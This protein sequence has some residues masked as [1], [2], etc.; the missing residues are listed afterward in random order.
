MLF[1]LFFFFFIA[2]R[3]APYCTRAAGIMNVSDHGL[4]CFTAVNYGVV[5]CC[6]KCQVDGPGYN[7]RCGSLY[8]FGETICDGNV[9]VTL[10]AEAACGGTGY[11]CL[12]TTGSD[13]SEI[14]PTTPIAGGGTPTTS[15]PTNDATPIRLYGPLLVVSF[16]LYAWCM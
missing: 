10:A 16:V 12:C 9:A 7:A 13:T 3:A 1:V 6:F 5:D 14:F 4:G 8:S 2:T 15:S 11:S